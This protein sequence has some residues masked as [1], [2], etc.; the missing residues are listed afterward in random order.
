[1]NCKAFLRSPLSAPYGSRLAIPPFRSIRLLQASQGLPLAYQGNPAC[2]CLAL[3]FSMASAGLA[4]L[5]YRKACLFGSIPI[6]FSKGKAILFPCV[7]GIHPAHASKACILSGLLRSSIVP[8]LANINN[9]CPCPDCLPLAGLRLLHIP[10][11]GLFALPFW[12]CLAGV[13]PFCLN[14]AFQSSIS[15]EKN[16]K[17]FYSNKIRHLGR[18]RKFQGWGRCARMP[19]TYPTPAQNFENPTPPMCPPYICRRKN[20]PSEKFWGNF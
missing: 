10:P 14:P 6:Q 17:I 4:F 1:M 9:H 8:A 11:N 2:S 12:A 16:K 19:T 7:S 5:A 18:Q 13:I 15:C 3:P 20:T